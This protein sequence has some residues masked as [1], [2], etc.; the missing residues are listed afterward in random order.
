[1]R[2]RFLLPFFVLFLGAASLPA[3]DKKKDDAKKADE[4]KLIPA[5]QLHG[6]LK[7]TG[8][9]KGDITVTVELILPDPRAQL[10][11]LQGQLQLMQALSLRNPLCRQQALAQAVG[12]MRGGGAGFVRKPI[13]L[14]LESADD[15]VVRTH[16]LPEQFDEKG[17]P[18]KYTSKQLKEMK[19]DNPNLPGYAADKDSLQTGQVVTIYLGHKKDAPKVKEKPKDKDA[20][21]D[22]DK[23]WE[24]ANKPLVRMI[25]IDADPP[26]K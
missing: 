9:S 11:K 14:D 6:V 7:N 15:L 23:L 21:K 4:E 3:D 24:E 26:S 5:G 1:M 12:T 19:G 25:V 13:D 8:G 10:T 2:K 17:K 20:P 18:K 16:V 22:K